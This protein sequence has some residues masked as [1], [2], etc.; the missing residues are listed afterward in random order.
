MAT[1]RLASFDNESVTFEVDYSDVNLKIS[2]FRCVNNGD[3]NAR[4]TLYSRQGEIIAQY[5]FEAGT[6][7]YADIGGNWRV[8]FDEYGDPVMPLDAK[9]EY[10]AP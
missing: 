3:Q 7:W 9:F 5:I 1:I 6:I 10:P 4:G 8:T 2:S